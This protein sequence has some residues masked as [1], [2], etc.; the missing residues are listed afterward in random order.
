MNLQEFNSSLPKP[1]LNINANS[2]NANSINANTFVV[3][4]IETKV[5][6]LENQVSVPNPAAG[7][8]SLYSNSSGI[9]STNNSLGTVLPYVSNPMSSDLD[10]NGKSINNLIFTN[11]VDIGQTMLISNASPNGN[12]NLGNIST[13][14][15]SLLID[16]FGPSSSASGPNEINIGAFCSTNQQYDIA[17]GNRINAT[18]FAS[19]NLGGGNTGITNPQNNS[20]AI[21]DDMT[22]GAGIH[23]I[24]IGQGAGIGAVSEAISLGA[25][26]V[27]NTAD[28]C[29]IGHSG[30]VNIRPNN[31][32]LCDLGSHTNQFNNVYSNVLRLPQASNSTSGVGQTLVAGV[33]VVNTTAVSTGDIVLL[34]CTA[35]GGTVGTPSISS[36]SNGVS[37]TI[38]SSSNAD[39][40][41]YSW[42]IIKQA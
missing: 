10:A 25:G 26:A 12:F 42:V 1:W 2:I 5:L 32:A 23:G 40:S 38:T 24:A 18:G 20:I 9:L 29:L 30:I 19:V 4:D 33:K 31:N 34:S 22:L 14:S 36:I 21:G 8:V 37:F 39:T 3:D 35:L 11:P 6:T 41:T 17:I 13:G 16:L 15:N 27:N 28:S 7:S